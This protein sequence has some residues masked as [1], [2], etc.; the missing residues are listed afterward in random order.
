[1]WASAGRGQVLKRLEHSLANSMT[2]VI[3]S[4]LEEKL[5]SYQDPD[6]EANAAS[7][8]IP[9]PRACCHSTGVFVLHQSPASTKQTKSTICL[10]GNF[11]T[12][13]MQH[14]FT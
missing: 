9:S 7:K 14:L 8:G 2:V 3:A 5:P 10:P 6:A 12:D 11:S 1:M 4:V 13:D